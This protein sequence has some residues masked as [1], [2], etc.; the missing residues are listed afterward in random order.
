[1]LT[2]LKVVFVNVYFTDQ[3]LMQRGYMELN[4]ESLEKKH[5]NRS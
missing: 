5:T 4:F 1:M 3:N 2:D